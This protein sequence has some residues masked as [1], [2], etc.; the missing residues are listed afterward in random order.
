VPGLRQN[1]FCARDPL[2]TQRSEVSS[3]RSE[4]CEHC[5]LHF[6]LSYSWSC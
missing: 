4:K 1:C 3:L 6:C 5:S 2:Q